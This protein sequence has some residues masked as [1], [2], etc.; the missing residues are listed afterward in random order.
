MLMK[1]KEHIDFHQVE[2]HQRAIDARLHNWSKWCN[3]SYVPL[4]SPM[5]RM[6]PPPPRVRADAYQSA[7][8]PVDKMDAAK[9]AKAVAGLPERHRSAINWHYIKPVS[10]RRACE[11]IGCGMEEL[12]QLVRDG[13]QMLINRKA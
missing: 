8:A 4:T 10:P 7:A 6:V 11:T 9:V 13:R 5:F 1:V 3:G 12:A 2:P